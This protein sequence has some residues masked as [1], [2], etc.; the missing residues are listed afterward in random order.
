MALGLP[1]YIYFRVANR[2]HHHVDV[3]TD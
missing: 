3:P 1:F 2:H